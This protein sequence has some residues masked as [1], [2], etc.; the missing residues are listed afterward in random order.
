MQKVGMTTAEIDNYFATNPTVVI[1]TGT[2]EEKRQQIITQK[3]LAWV[4]NGIEAYN[5]YRRTRYPPLALA[6]NPS[7]DNPNVIPERLPYTPGEL[8]ANPNAPKPRPKTD[9]KVWWA[10]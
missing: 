8:A 6:L 1:L 10:K 7:G 9:V 3:Y 2:T 4:G 5:D